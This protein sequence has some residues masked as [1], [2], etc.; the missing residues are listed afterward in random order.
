MT[1]AR[2]TEIIDTPDVS[3]YPNS[4]GQPYGDPM[5]V[6]SDAVWVPSDVRSWA[7][8]KG[9]D[10]A[11]R[12]RIPFQVVELYLARPAVVRRW[13]QRHGVE[14]GARGRIPL[15]VVEQY[16]TRP[17]AVRAWARDRNRAISARGRIPAEVTADYLAQFGDLV[18]TAA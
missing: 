7:R 12:G 1:H 15:G 10:V 3:D 14:V 4:G 5:T 17:E 6:D 16:L 18:R 11:G 13:A 9:I 8:E 2:P